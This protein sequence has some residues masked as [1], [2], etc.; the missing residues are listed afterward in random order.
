[1]SLLVSPWEVGLHFDQLLLEC[2]R[3]HYWCSN[4]V[5]LILNLAH[6]ILNWANLLRICHNG[7]Y[8]GISLHLVVEDLLD[9][10]RA[11]PFIQEVLPL[12]L[13]LGQLKG[14]LWFLSELGHLFTDKV[15][16]WVLC[17]LD[18]A[19]CKL[20]FDLHRARDYVGIFWY[21]KLALVGT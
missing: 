21:L 11:K 15:I 5:R 6:K 13:V 18:G 19:S 7:D 1:L 17:H 14:F 10:P 8:L 3:S 9:L 4:L 2:V 16:F 12:D 20:V